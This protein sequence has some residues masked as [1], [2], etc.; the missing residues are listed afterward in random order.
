MEKTISPSKHAMPYGITFGIIVVLQFMIMYTLDID[1]QENQWAGIIVNLLNYIFLPF[2][3][4]YIAA[5]K[6]KKEFNDGYLSL[7]QTLKIGVSICVLAAVIY[8]I[9][10]ILFN[11]LFPEFQAELLDKIQ[12]VTV[13]QNPTMTAEQLKMSMKFVKIFLN[14][15]IAAPFTIVMYAVIGLVHSLVVGVILKKEKPIF[16]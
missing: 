11:F 1:P 8:G 9:F 14:P 12:E 16:N 6:F 7:S 4:I 3:L 2:I 10:Y 5:N 13:K 15:Y